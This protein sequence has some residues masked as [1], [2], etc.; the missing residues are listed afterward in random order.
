MKIAWRVAYFLAFGLA[1]IHGLF[2]TVRWWQGEAL[3]GLEYALLAI[4]PVLF[5]YFITRYSIFKRGCT[6][7]LRE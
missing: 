7:C 6:A 4:W 5:Y 1:L 2:V 3:T